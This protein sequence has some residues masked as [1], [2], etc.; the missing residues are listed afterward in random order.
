MMK[1]GFLG[2]AFVGSIASAQIVLPSVFSDH[3]VLQQGISLPV[4][5]T[6]SAHQPVKIQ[7]VDDAGKV[8]A[9]ATGVCAANGRFRESLPPVGASSSPHRLRIAC[10]GETVERSD[11]LIGEVWLCGGQSNM[12]F[13]LGGSVGGE[14][15]AQKLPS[16]V[17]CFT[18]PHEM[19]PHPVD[20][21]VAAWVVASPS[22]SG[23]FTAVGS[24]FASE[25]G[26]SL[27][28][29]VGLLSINWGGSLAEAWTPEDLAT[30]H[31]LFAGR[32]AQQAE[33][34][35]AFEMKSAA[36]RQRELEQAQVE[37]ARECDE[38]WK[39]LLSGD[40]GWSGGW[41]QQS[42]D[43]SNG[44]SDGR[45]P[46]VFESAPETT[47]LRNFDGATWWR[48]SLEVPASWAGREAKVT[49]GPIDDSDT[50]WVNGTAIGRTTGLHQAPRTYSVP[51][52]LLRAGKN[53]IA[54]LVV[55]TGGPAG[56]SIA[57]ER[58][59]LRL[60]SMQGV[61]EADAV[62]IPLAGSWKWK[63]G[64]SAGGKF[65]PSAPTGPVHPQAQWSSL[66]SMWN[67]MMAPVASYGIRGALWYQGESN[68]DRAMEYR[69]LL[70]LMIDAWRQKWGEGEFPFGVVQLASF[71]AASDDPVEGGWANLRD[72]QLATARNHK[73]CGMAVTIDVGDAVD[74]H[75]T[76]K[77]AV[78]HRLAVWALSQV[79]GKSVDWSGPLYRSCK[80][81]GDSLIVSFDHATGLK[82]SD[83]NDLGGFAIAGADGKF[84]WA[85]ATIQGD[86]VRLSSPSVKSPLTVRYAWSNN[87]VRANLVN[88]AGL[89][90]SPFASDTH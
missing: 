34:G 20:D 10:G 64:G 68:A 26:R 43:S 28:V 76:N 54:I 74:I 70:P 6:A 7:L 86:T 33:L 67:G 60:A 15:L 53:D 66:G 56:F 44:W 41:L 48:K 25:I 50:V 12:E 84:S 22:T 72:A 45:L 79:Y 13:A 4:W 62:P 81:E 57:P 69:E 18:S 71:Q 39:V 35:K 87:P 65:A 59:R 32:A 24:W 17:R 55:D 8:I 73:N 58:M 1:I 42:A 89:P 29:P 3:M 61:G 85:N 23:A 37:Y 47:Q 9:S 11:V 88:G 78:G 31:P 5:G 36:V 2:V 77:A 83:G 82:T 30:A 75:P 38:Y 52:G 27:E 21:Q 14:Q 40:P 49:L 16:T 46:C 51:S 90:A 63:Q 19:A 80:T